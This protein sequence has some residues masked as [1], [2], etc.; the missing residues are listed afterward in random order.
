VGLLLDRWERVLDGAGQAVMVGGEAGVG[1]S[2]LVEILRDRL[3]GTPHTWLEG[4]CSPFLASSPFHP[5][6]ELLRLGVGWNG[7]APPE[8]A[9]RHLRS[10]L[11]A[12]GLDVRSMLAPLAS[13]LSVPIPDD[14]EPLPEDPDALRRRT[15]DA[16][17]TWFLGLADRQPVVLVLE[18]LHWS[19]PSTLE[20]LGRILEQSAATRLLCVA[21]HRPEFLP[22]WPA[23]T[24]VSQLSLGPLTR[25][26][27]EEMVRA[28]AGKRAFDPRMIQGV[29]ERA[30]GNPLYVE[31]LVKMLQETRLLDE[32]DEG[33]IAIPQTLHDSLMARFD[34]LESA[35]TVAQLG[36]VLGREFPYRLLATVWDRGSEALAA[37]LRRLVEAELLYQR[38]SVPEAVFQFK[39]ALIQDTAYQSLLRRQRREIHARVAKALEAAGDGVR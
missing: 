35:K 11:E 30:D 5:V 15:F 23:R 7:Q 20:L 19:D 22:S 1:K 4:R 9:L 12:C 26:Q 37:D 32:R 33:D 10:S 39:H 17:V 27:T 18:D 36:S 2:R 13:L 6:I 8:E 14:A 31:E 29:L 24:H 3:A 25:R 21:T 38:G 28:A 16:L 34:R